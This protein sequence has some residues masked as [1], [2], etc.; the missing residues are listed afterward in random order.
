VP[1]QEILGE[2]LGAF[3][4]RGDR[5]RPEDAQAGG[6]EPVDHAGHQRHLRTDHGQPDFFALRQLQQAIEITHRDVGV[7]HA[8]LA[9][10][11]G[12][13]GRHDH[14]VDLRGLP[15]LPR[16]RVFATAAADDEDLHWAAPCEARHPAQRDIVAAT[17]P[18]DGQI[19]VLPPTEWAARLTRHR[20]LRRRARRFR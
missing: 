4:L 7:A 13:A 16:Q 17:L 20:R 10:G 1:L 5:T 11:T 12:V 14:F 18:A 15:E 19:R 3:Q 9:R 2:R 8:R 6:T